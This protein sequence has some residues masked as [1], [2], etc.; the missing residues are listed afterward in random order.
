[1]PILPAL[2]RSA[3]DGVERRRFMAAIAGGLLAAPLAAEAQHSG[4]VWRIGVL[5][6]LGEA[7]EG[8]QPNPD[9]MFE[10][11]R[12]GLRE[13]G[14]TEGQNILV[15]PRWAKGQLDRFPDLAAELVRIKVDVIVAGGNQA[16]KAAKQATRTI[17]IVMVS[18][19]AVAD[20]LVSS[21]ARPGGNV[22]GVTIFSS[23]LAAKRL[24][25][26]KETV[27]GLTHVAILWNSANPGTALQVREAKRAAQ[28]LGLEVQSVEVRD[29]KEL[30]RAFQL[31]AKGRAGALL[32][33][34]DAGFDAH[35]VRIAELSAKAKLPT[36]H[37]FKIH[38]EA[39]GLMSYGQNIS[40]MFRRA[41]LYVDKILK[42]AKP[43]DRPVEQAT[44]F[45]LVINLKT[46]K[47]LGLTIPPSLLARADEV[48][49]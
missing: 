33:V 30:G 10:G 3:A 14:Y 47:A 7:S 46:A 40:D 1:M 38:V 44:K 19:D 4:K 39:G 37:A 35:R 23:E 36:I 21:L 42:G 45:E 11:F 26:L 32:V 8:S 5:D 9:M 48:I 29:P 18:G 25:L 24:E 15:E 41:A 27:P 20:G 34:S 31:A 17:P 2:D 43:A 16:V 12:Q 49:Q 22:T 28:A 6:P 13:A